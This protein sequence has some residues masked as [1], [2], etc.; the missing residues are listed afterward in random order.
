MTDK[1]NKDRTKKPKLYSFIFLASVVFVYLILFLLDREGVHEA[2]KVSGKIFVNLIPVFLLV[3][4][5]MGIMNTLFKPKAVSKYLGKDSGIKGW[6]I[7][8]LSGILSHGPIY[9]WYPLL[10]EFRQKGMR[11][12]LIGT[13]LYNRA[14]KLPL[15][16]A[17]IYYFGTVF[18]ILLLVS[19]IGASLIEGKILEITDG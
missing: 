15:L 6:F 7:A 2:L 12:G 1:N 13:F 5:F 4:V 19:M 3:I 10:K 16:P 11:T 18:S 14:I 8:V 9:V 17:L